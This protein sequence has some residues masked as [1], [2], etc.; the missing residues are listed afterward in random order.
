MVTLSFLNLSGPCK[1]FFLK[2]ECSS[3][4]YL[5]R[6]IP[7]QMRFSFGSMGNNFLSSCVTKIGV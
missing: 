5:P 7:L 6:K 1:A 3:Y 2:G 4:L